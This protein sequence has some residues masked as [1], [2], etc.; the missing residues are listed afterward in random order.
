LDL[1][2]ALL[3]LNDEQRLVLALHY[4]LDLPIDEVAATLR[5]SNS[6]A[7]SRVSRAVRALRPVLETTEEVRT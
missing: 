1:E 7:K 4:Y 5:I 2:S 3:K 6:A